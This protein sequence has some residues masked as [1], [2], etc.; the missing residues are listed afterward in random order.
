MESPA[1]SPR[2]SAI[3]DLR[4]DRIGVYSLW[5]ADSKY[6]IQD[7][8]GNTGF[9]ELRYGVK[10]L[11]AI[12]ERLIEDPLMLSRVAFAQIIRTKIP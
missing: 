11:R 9:P 10:P 12:I 7:I 2:P 1:S 6:M 4:H 5:S 3:G 8:Y